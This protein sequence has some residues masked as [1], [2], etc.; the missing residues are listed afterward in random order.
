MLMTSDQHAANAVPRP[1]AGALAKRF[2]AD[3]V[4][5]VATSAYQIEGAAQEDGRGASIW[6]QFCRRPGAI[7]DGSSGERACDH[8]TAWPRTLR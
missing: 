8:Y 3:F 5:G 4:W 6:D 7:K 2:P 1:E